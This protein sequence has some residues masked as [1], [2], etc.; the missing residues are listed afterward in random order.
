M[1]VMSEDMYRYLIYLYFRYYSVFII[2]CVCRASDK[3]VRSL[4]TSSIV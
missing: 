2:L 4:F 3:L 1:G